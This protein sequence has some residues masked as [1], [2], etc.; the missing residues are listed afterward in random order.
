MEEN[1]SIATTQAT[2]A[3]QADLDNLD[4]REI[5]WDS[6]SDSE[7]EYGDDSDDE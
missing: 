4:E 3:T 7:P 2:Q 1:G 5:T 6:E